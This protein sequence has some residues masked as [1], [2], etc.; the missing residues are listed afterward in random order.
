M[1]IRI[2]IIANAFG[3]GDRQALGTPLAYNKFVT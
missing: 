3:K 2:F 1:A